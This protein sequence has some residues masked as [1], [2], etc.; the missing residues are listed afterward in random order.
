MY[1]S[2]RQRLT[3]IERA[4]LISRAAESLIDNDQVLEAAAVIDISI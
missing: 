1:C 2:A 4:A 3:H